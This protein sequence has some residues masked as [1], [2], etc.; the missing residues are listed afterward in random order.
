[1]IYDLVEI[2]K[3]IILHFD[4]IEKKIFFIAE[5]KCYNIEEIKDI[6]EKVIDK[7]IKILSIPY[8]IGYISAYLN[9]KFY[10]IFYKQPAI[11]N[12]DKLK[13]LS[14]KYWL[15][16]SNEIKNFLP[17]FNYTPLEIGIEKTYKWYKQNNWL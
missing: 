11:F 2:L 4:Q 6:F 8:F 14:K 17:K 10:K 9:E 15:C 1:F 16:Y 7:K 5:D 13:E 3:Q 12:R